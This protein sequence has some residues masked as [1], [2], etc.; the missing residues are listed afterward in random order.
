MNCSCSLPKTTA[1]NPIEWETESSS[2]SGKKTTNNFTSKLSAYFNTK[3][4]CVQH[5][6]TSG[7][8]NSLVISWQTT[9]A[10]WETKHP[11]AGL[12][13]K[14][15][16]GAAAAYDNMN[17]HQKLKPGQ[18][19]SFHLTFKLISKIQFIVH[20]HIIIRKCKWR[21]QVCQTL[22]IKS[23]QTYSDL[24]THTETPRPLCSLDY[25]ETDY[26]S[27]VCVIPN[28]NTLDQFWTVN[29]SWAHEGHSVHLFSNVWRTEHLSHLPSLHNL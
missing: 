20:H 27:S 6:T 14:H 28:H 3:H 8:S 21:K 4:F 16:D 10:P 19:G 15:I 22:N 17:Q 7:R 13:Q 26:L 18:N 9:D 2:I 5:Q 12:K 23:H 29:N 1:I 25:L 11:A 24:S